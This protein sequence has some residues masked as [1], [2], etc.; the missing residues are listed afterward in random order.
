[1][2]SDRPPVQERIDGSIT[3]GH[4]ETTGGEFDDRFDLI[5]VKAVEPFHDVVDIGPTSRFSKLAAT[6]IRVPRSTHAPMSL[7]ETLSTSGHWDQS[8]F[9]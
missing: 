4:I 7:P 9:I 6:G 3:P 8:G 2:Q 1:V 5:A